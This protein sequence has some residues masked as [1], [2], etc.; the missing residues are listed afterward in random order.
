MQSVE[1]SGV[2]KVKDLLSD[3]GRHLWLVVLADERGARDSADVGSPLNG[4]GF[5]SGSTFRVYRTVSRG[6]TI[7]YHGVVLDFGPLTIV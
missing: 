1:E 7:E 4:L 5:R 2:S 6:C 3:D